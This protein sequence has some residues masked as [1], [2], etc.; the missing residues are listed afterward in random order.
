MRNHPLNKAFLTLVFSLSAVCAFAQNEFK[1]RADLP[2]IDSG[3]FYRIN[4]QPALIAKSK[5]DLSDIRISD[6]NGKP[7]PYIFGYNLPSANKKDFA[8][9][10]IVQPIINNDT[11]T[12]FR[13]QNVDHLNINQLYVRFRNTIV[14]RNIDISGSDDLKQWYA[15]EEN[16][17]LSQSAGNSTG[18]YEQSFNF[19][20]STYNF[21]KITI[22]HKHREPVAILKAGIY[23]EQFA[24]PSYTEIDGVSFSQKDSDKVSR[25]LIKFK[26]AYQVNRLSFWVAGS[27]FYKRNLRLYQV[28]KG[29]RDLIS[30]SE[31]SSQSLPSLNLSAKGSTFQMEI[32]NDDNPALTVKGIK[33]FQ[34]D[35]SL[36]SYLEKGGQYYIQFGD[37]A[38]IA[39]HYDIK[40]FTDSLHQQL[41]IINHEVI[42]A[43]SAYQNK[44]IKTT[45]GIPS[46]V[47]WVAIS[48]V[49]ALLAM[50]TFKMTGEVKKREA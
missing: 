12:V 14:E 33:A 36:I 13:I 3:N 9:L 19:P 22:N 15:I 47:I 45:S 49:I 40:V 44:L 50:L 27:K 1:Y 39:P 42:T 7:V 24:Q 23:K 34:L 41:P 4:L 48:I 32:N 35:Q 21:F 16:V 26:D 46:W 18:V 37:S 30:E 17:A 31:L 25:I 38:A 20:S 5:A 10:P 28:T 29:Y 11:L 6:Q 2:K 43:N 8:E